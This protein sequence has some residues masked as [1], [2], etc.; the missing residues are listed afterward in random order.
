MIRSADF[1]ADRYQQTLDY[2][3]QA[4]VLDPDFARAY[5]A[6]AIASVLDFVNG[7]SGDD[8][9]TIKRRMSEN[10]DRAL[11]LAPE[12]P[13][14]LQIS[15]VVARFSKDLPKA[16]AIINKA[17]ELHPNAA[18]LLFSRGEIAVYS[19][20]PQEAIVDLER[21]N[22]L[23]PDNIHQHLQF[24]GLAHLLL[25]HDETAA[26][27]FRERILLA[28]ET[29]SGR[30]G[31]A[32]ALGQLGEAEEAKRVWNEILEIKPNFSMRKRMDVMVFEGHGDVSRVFE[33]L[34][35]AGLPLN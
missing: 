25:G 35:K 14:V 13:Q 22:R 6:V 18:G 2:A 7:L 16:Q 31:L 24:L 19:G 23:D 26:M 27:L 34:E 10:A 9:K 28:R 1:N 5:S 12:D 8:A 30:A 4:Q 11:K 33:G 21:A 3:Q 29:D 32:S 17:M 15:A 20:H